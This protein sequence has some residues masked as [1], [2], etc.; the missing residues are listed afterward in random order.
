MTSIFVKDISSDSKKNT[1]FLFISDEDKQSL[2]SVDPSLVSITKTQQK[3]LGL[4]LNSYS[5]LDHQNTVT[6][7]ELA[8][9]FD[10]KVQTLRS[11]IRKL[12][13]L[14]ILINLPF[15]FSNA[16]KIAG[17]GLSYDQFDFDKIKSLTEDQSKSDQIKANI[18]ER[19]NEI[20]SY[21]PQ[22]MLKKLN[23]GVNNQARIKKNTDISTVPVVQP[24]GSFLLSQ[25]S[26]KQQRPRGLKAKRLKEGQIYS[27]E[28]KEVLV[29]SSDGQ[30]LRAIVTSR[31]Y[32]GLMDPADLQVLLAIY[33]LTYR[34]HFFNINQYFEDEKMPAPMTPIYVDDIVLLIGRSLGGPN[35]EYV[36]DCIRSINDTEH[37]TSFLDALEI[38]IDHTVKQ[39][40]INEGNVF[41]NFHKC[42]ALSEEKPKIVNGRRV[43]GTSSI[44]MIALPDSI[45][46]SLMSNQLLLSFPVGSL[47]L[48][49][50]L[51]TLYM[52]FRAKCKKQKNLEEGKTG[53]NESLRHT[54]SDLASKTESYSKFK[55]NLQRCLDDLHKKTQI[56]LSSFFDADSSTYRFNLYGYH[57]ELS[58]EEDFYK[59]V[60]HEKEM[61]SCCNS[62]I[63]DLNKSAP[64]VFNE[65]SSLYKDQI[66]PVA[67]KH[68]TAISTTSK[69]RFD[70][71]YT[72]I[73]GSK[74]SIHKYAT[75]SEIDK[76]AHEII[77]VTKNDHEL[78]L[79]HEAICDDLNQISG[80]SLQLETES[81]AVTNEFYDELMSMFEFNYEY[82]DHVT[83]CN[84]ITRKQSCHQEIYNC[85]LN[86][87]EPSIPL[88]KF[89]NELSMLELR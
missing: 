62:E 9:V 54:Y 34:Y 85:I 7:E 65:L 82:I 53:F 31:S 46:E 24:S 11:S 76:L 66:S 43:L 58:F 64:V 4:L 1:S 17:K 49:P 33:A 42:V 30:T 50:L 84:R 72:L 87:S 37:D 88:L 3:I 69:R 18:S 26:S 75:N 74:H 2:V 55:S 25:L 5:Y 56:H 35:R 45:F 73:D 10:I 57:A 79:L 6:Y 70:V 71:V 12:R 60:C 78:M 32:S 68:L 27:Q 63:S 89:M 67:K 59:V 41:R 81:F 40:Y 19:R 22:R 38:Q 52:R 28:S 48:P 29:K 16:N 39:M 21:G 13:N 44:Y 77:K 36:R 83:L 15:M 14:G 80:M 61:L 51:F 86:G 47:S 20:S 8:L 23:I